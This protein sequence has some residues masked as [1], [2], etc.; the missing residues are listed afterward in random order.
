MSHRRS[1]FAVAWLILFLVITSTVWSEGCK[2]RGG[3]SS[4]PRGA[5]AASSPATRSICVREMSLERLVRD[6]HGLLTNKSAKDAWDEL[7]RRRDRDCVPLLLDALNDPDAG[8]LDCAGY[9]L[10]AELG[11][12]RC[13][14]FLIAIADRYPCTQISGELCLRWGPEWESLLAKRAVYF[15]VE[16]RHREKWNVHVPY[17]GNTTA[18]EMEQTDCYKQLKA[19]YDRVNQWYR[20][21]R[22]SYDHTRAPNYRSAVDVWKEVPSTRKQQGV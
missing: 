18:A 17:P 19:A 5:T 15:I 16:P 13:F 10:I 6:A 3:G 12:E 22:R 11:D 21:W 4:P 20:V 9:D 8:D 7:V 14:P 1:T 2:R